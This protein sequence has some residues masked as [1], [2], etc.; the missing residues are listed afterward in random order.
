MS[1]F[2]REGFI[3]CYGDFLERKSFYYSVEF[4]QSQN[5]D[6]LN[7]LE[8]LLKDYEQLYIRYYL[9]KSNAYNVMYYQ[10]IVGSLIAIA[11]V[12]RERETM[13]TIK[14]PDKME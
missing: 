12:R 13:L 5:D 3:K 1:S 4:L 10:D 11:K 7:C 9:E 8:K 2:S 14:E 6:E